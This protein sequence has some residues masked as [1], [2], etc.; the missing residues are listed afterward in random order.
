MKGPVKLYRLLVMA[1][2]EAQGKE[3]GSPAKRARSEG[4]EALKVSNPEPR[5]DQVMLGVSGFGCLYKE[6]EEEQ[7]AALPPPA[8]DFFSISRFMGH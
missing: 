2:D 6:V 7:L 8:V 4:D 3:E 5:K 1:V